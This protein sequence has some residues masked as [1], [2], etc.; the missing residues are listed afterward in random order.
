MP[1][2]IGETENGRLERGNQLSDGHFEERDF[3]RSAVSAE[4]RASVTIAVIGCGYWGSKHVRVLSTLA[5][6]HQV[7]IVEPDPR[8]RAAI[9]SAFPATRAFPDLKS[10]LPHV[11]A[12][13]IATPPQTHTGLAL[14]ALRSGKHVLV[15]KPLTKSLEEARLLVNEARRSNSVLMAGH[16]FLFNPAVKELRNRLVRGELGEVYYVYSARLNLGLY[17]C[18][19]NVVWD[20]APHDITIMNYLLHS[21]PTAV[22]A[23][24]GSLA[25]E[26]V[27]DIAYIRL[28]YGKLGVSGFIQLSWLDP[29]KARTVTVVG[30][31]K[32][33]VYDDLA[34]ER[35]RIY[36]RGLKNLEDG[37]PSYDR[38]LSYRYGD[39]ISPHIPSEEPL[40]L[41]DQHFLD[42]IC[43][44][45]TPQSSGRDG[46]LVI[47]VLEA[48]DQAL[49]KGIT[50]EVDY[51]VDLSEISD[52]GPTVAS[53]SARLKDDFA[54]GRGQLHCPR[55]NIQ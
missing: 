37:S 52:A 44:R 3:N 43:N 33:A 1:G 35:L 47:A 12:V 2:M 42:C 45:A 41:E 4:N 24:S 17:R 40:A 9:L 20:L 10:S 30:K 16:T 6:V 26:K 29:R 36:D 7:A 34:E 8:S 27:E 11:D 15:E 21:V 32:M 25:R 46:M 55:T 48:I 13:V 39:I 14:M 50:I 38:P 49:Q 5:N 53:G 31:D 19:V 22:S 28:D 54:D 18:D 23:W 51:P